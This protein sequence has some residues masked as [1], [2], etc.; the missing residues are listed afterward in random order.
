[1]CPLSSVVA[2]AAATHTTKKETVGVTVHKDPPPHPPQTSVEFCVSK[3]KPN[4]H[5][6]GNPAGLLSNFICRALT[7]ENRDHGGN[8]GV[9]A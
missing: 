4:R 3:K 9:L 8:R 7:M 6:Q 2:A 1:M 5:Y